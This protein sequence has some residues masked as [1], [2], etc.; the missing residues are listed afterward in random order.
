VESQN[1]DS[2]AM[3]WERSRR[4]PTKP[5]RVVSGQGLIRRGHLDI[6][7]MFGRGAPRKGGPAMNPYDA[8]YNARLQGVLIQDNPWDYTTS[9]HAEWNRGW[10]QASASAWDE[11]CTTPRVR[12][13]GKI[14]EC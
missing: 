7:H 13:H 9:E 2:T 4:K 11:P 10:R 1:C 5:Q 12:D 14:R 3:T 8:G 6:E